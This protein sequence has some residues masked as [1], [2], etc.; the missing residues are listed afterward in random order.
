VI[1]MFCDQVRDARRG[2]YFTFYLD[3]DVLDTVGHAETLAL[4]N[5]LVA[6]TNQTLVG[7]DSDT[8]HTG[9]VV[10]QGRYLLVVRLLTTEDTI[11]GRTYL[12]CLGFIVLTPAILVNGLLAKTAST[13]GRATLGR[14]GALSTAEVEGLVEDDNTGFAVTKVRDQLGSGGR[15]HSSDRTAS[16]DALCETFSS[17]SNTSSADGADECCKSRRE[18]SKRSHDQKE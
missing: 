18:E 10:S 1:A 17:T 13:P 11:D 7:V 3:N 16:S 9:L 5:T 12:R 14:G 2:M 6:L 15:V 4:D 8:N